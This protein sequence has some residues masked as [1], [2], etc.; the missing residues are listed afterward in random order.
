MYI[1]MILYLCEFSAHCMMINRNTFVTKHHK[2]EKFGENPMQLSIKL[3]YFN[4]CNFFGEDA[5]KNS[6]WEK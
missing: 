5:G 1:L 6:R 2:F 4:L 3:Q